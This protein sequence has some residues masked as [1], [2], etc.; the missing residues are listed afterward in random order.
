VIASYRNCGPGR[1]D[2]Q[3]NRC[4]YGEHGVSPKMS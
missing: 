2:G 1:A 4:K 3:S